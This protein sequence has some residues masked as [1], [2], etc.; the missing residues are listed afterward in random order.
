MFAE[1]R[2]HS[3][4]ASPPSRKARG[5]SSTCMSAPSTP[6]SLTIAAAEAGGAPSVKCAI[7]AAA[8]AVPA[9]QARCISA[10]S[11]RG[12]AEQHAP[13]LLGEGSAGV[14][15][16]V[17]RG[18]LLVGAHGGRTVVDGL[19]PA[20][21]MRE[22]LELLSLRFVRHDPGVGGDIGDR[23]LTG[24]ERTGAEGPG[25]HP[26]QAVRLLHVALPGGGK[27]LG[28]GSGGRLG[29]AGDPGPAPPPAE[30][31]LAGPPGAP[32][33]GWGTPPP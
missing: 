8:A 28:G 3:R 14:G 15:G 7:A 9:G 11:A 5:S 2:T 13:R 1:R 20:L 26:V 19:E 31:A 16:G 17:D 30:K 4:T 10:P 33:H 12:L 21:Q 24:D 22:I 29:L 6:M 32:P 23:V 25:Q 18:R 27:R